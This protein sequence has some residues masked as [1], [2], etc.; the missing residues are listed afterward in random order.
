MKL[1]GFERAVCNRKESMDVVVVSKFL[2]DYCKNNKVKGII[3]LASEGVP[4]SS[5]KFNKEMHKI[6]KGVDY[7]NA[8]NSCKFYEIEY[9]LQSDDYKDELKEKENK[10]QHLVTTIQH[11]QIEVD[12]NLK[13][14]EKLTKI[15][16]DEKRK[17]D[18]LVL[19]HFESR[20]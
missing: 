17:Y 12:V 14:I 18:E 11:L 20:L 7:I 15:L 13:E 1:I 5:K 6:F 8:I 19:K 3:K 9:K 2:Q 10:I 16:N 4:V